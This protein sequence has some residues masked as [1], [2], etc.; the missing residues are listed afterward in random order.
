MTLTT[1]YSFKS[2]I[3]PQQRKTLNALKKLGSNKDLI[4]IKPD[5]GNGVA[6]LNKTDYVR[7]MEHLLPDFTSSLN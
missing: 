7:K 6:L 5:K 1:C 4:I 2:K 3:S